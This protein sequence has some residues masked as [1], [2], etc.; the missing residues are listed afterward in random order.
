MVEEGD[1]L[2]AMSLPG[3]LGL[4]TWASKHQR[5]IPFNGSPPR[6]FSRFPPLPTLN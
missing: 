2:G 1:L 6:A 4:S 5:E 3:A